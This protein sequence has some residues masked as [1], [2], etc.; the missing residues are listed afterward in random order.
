MALDFPCITKADKKTGLLAWGGDLQ[1]ENLL[2]A[3]SSGIFPWPLT[4][5]GTLLW[6]APPHRAVLFLESF[7]ASRRLQKKLKS[8]HF[9]FTINESFEAVIRACASS[10]NRKGQKLSWIT[11]EMIQGYIQL[12]KAGFCH[13]VEC[14]KEGQ[15]VGGL[16]GVAIGK[17]FAGESMFYLESDASKLSLCFLVDYLHQKGVEWIDCQQ[18]TP[19]LESFGAVEIERADF[20]RLLFNAITQNNRLFD[21][22]AK[23]T[24]FSWSGS[25]QKR[26][27]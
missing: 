1:V 16:Y 2:Q 25:K 12:Y 3:Y 19:L 4:E 9:R 17:M 18:K 24:S 15:L 10:P 26:G 23:G 6:F 20:M 7:H 11:E 5:D 21:G 13:S 27:L 22:I 8:G 14:L